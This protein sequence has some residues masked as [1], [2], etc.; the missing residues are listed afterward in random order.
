MTE[1]K[2][3]PTAGRLHLYAVS[4]DSGYQDTIE[5]RTDYYLEESSGFVTLIE[6]YDYND[7]RARDRR[8]EVTRFEIRADRLVALIRQHGKEV[9]PAA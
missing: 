3:P 8:H 5:T 7:M 1:S 4:K 2:T 9:P 6:E